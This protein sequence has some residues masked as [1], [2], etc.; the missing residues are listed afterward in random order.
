MLPDGA[1]AQR[2]KDV[3]DIARTFGD[4]VADFFAKPQIWGM[5]AF[6]FFYRSAEG[7][8]L[9]EGEDGWRRRTGPPGT[10]L[11]AVVAQETVYVL[12]ADGDDVALWASL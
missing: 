12:T 1:V 5:L 3:S 6:V 10:P 4:S 8:L 9:V 11:A 2:P 7:L